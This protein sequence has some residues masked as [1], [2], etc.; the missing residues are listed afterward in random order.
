MSQDK[1]GQEKSLL[2]KHQ[3]T[4]HAWNIISFYIKRAHN[5]T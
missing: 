4:L 3:S 2:Q 1:V 5:T